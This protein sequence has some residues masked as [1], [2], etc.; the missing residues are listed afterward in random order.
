MVAKWADDHFGRSLRRCYAELTRS[1]RELTQELN[2]DILLLRGVACN[3]FEAFLHN[4]CMN[5]FSFA[6]ACD[7][8][9]LFVYA[10]LTQGFF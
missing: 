3:V 2:R 5:A 1:L 8:G 9:R 7:R 10:E 4:V 6:Y